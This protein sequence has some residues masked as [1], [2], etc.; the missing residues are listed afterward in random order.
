VNELKRSTLHSCRM[1]HLLTWLLVEVAVVA[2]QPL[3]AALVVGAFVARLA[4][5]AFVGT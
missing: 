1:E 4:W 5:H 2:I 3:A